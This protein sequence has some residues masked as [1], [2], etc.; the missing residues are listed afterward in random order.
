MRLFGYAR[1]SSSQQSLAIQMKS[2]I[3][4]GVID[5]TVKH[6]NWVCLN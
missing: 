5:Y 4:A 3:D 6:L 1:V 2:L